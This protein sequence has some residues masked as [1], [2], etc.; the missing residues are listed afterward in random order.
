MYLR[1]LLVNLFLTLALFAENTDAKVAKSR[2]LPEQKSEE[3]QESCEHGKTRSHCNECGFLLNI[4]N[5]TNAIINTAS[6]TSGTIINDL[7]E[8]INTTNTINTTTMNTQST[9]NNINTNVNTLL[10]QSCQII[11]LTLSNTTPTIISAPGYY[12]VTNSVDMPITGAPLATPNTT[13]IINS[14]DVTL[15]LCGH[16]LTG[17]GNKTAATIISPAT[18]GIQNDTRQDAC[19]CISINPSGSASSV[20]DN[21]TITNGKIQYYSVN[22]IT[23][24][25]VDNLTIEDLLVE[26]CSTVTAAF[27]TVFTVTLRE[28]TSVIHNNVH[29]KSNRGSD[30]VI[31]NRVRQG[32]ADIKITNSSSIGLRGGVGTFTNSLLAIPAYITFGVTALSF[33]VRAQT[34]NTT[35]DNVLVENCSVTDAKTCAQVFGIFF[36][37]R[38]NGGVI[39]NCRITSVNQVTSDLTIFP[40]SVLTIEARGIAVEQ[41]SRG[42]LV[43]NCTVQDISMA[44]TIAPI[45]PSSASG[46]GFNEVTGGTARNCIVRNISTAGKVT[47]TVTSPASLVDCS[48]HAFGT[49]A[50]TNFAGTNLRELSWVNCIAS[51]IDGGSSSA[52]PSFGIG[53]KIEITT[54]S[55]S[56][57][58][59]AF[60][61]FY[62]NCLAQDTVGSNQSAGFT[63]TMTEPA[64]PVVYENCVT[65][66][67][68]IHGPNKL[69]NGFLISPGNNITMRGCTATGHTLNGFDLSGYL[70]AS[71]TGNAKFILD[72]C[73]ANGNSGYGFRLDHS[74]KQIELIDCK[75]TNNG[76][77]GINAAGR[78]MVFRNTVSDINLGKGF[79]FDQYY[80][81]FAKV[82]TDTSNVGM[83]N[84][85]V[86][87]VNGYTVAYTS[88]SQSLNIIPN[89]ASD[90]LPASLT[91]NGVTVNNGD[92]VLIKDLTGGN[93]N[94]GGQRNGVYQASNSTGSAVV[95]GITV[96][97]WQLIRVDPWRAP[98]TVP[99]GTKIL[100]AQSNAPNL[101]PGPVMYTLNTNVVVD[102][103]NITSANFIA[104]QAVAPDASIIEVAN[105]AAAQNSLNGFHNHAKDVTVR[106]CV[107]D[108]NGSVGFLDDVVGGALANANLYTRNRAFNND[109]GTTLGNYTIDYVIPANPTVLQTGTINPPVFPSAVAPEANVSITPS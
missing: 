45:A 61:A 41:S 60:S 54:G 21:I 91:I 11:P 58:L 84:L 26:N 43:E 73:I 101:T 46:I 2:A 108:R 107:A 103:T 23:A 12:K 38:V 85:G 30:F 6:G 48:A 65:E 67:D 40:A 49:S 80:P 28:C 7:N 29:Y 109:G 53:F 72:N 62:S 105:C 39:R 42:A 88:S 14:G 106:D 55:S 4:Y 77:D 64:T 25:Y 78:N 89:N 35:I 70:V 79:F 81:F 27:F 34:A 97:I 95:S 15:D 37:N 59:K 86:Y 57:N 13:I 24:Q 87:I 5:N 66:Q 92:I 104:T 47:V 10:G 76:L 16:V 36:Q 71:S 50:V 33:V 99:T 102:T 19:I 90:P 31:N 18:V 68:R 52:N 63:M 8:I 1:N 51:N 9:V 82:A 17:S 69:S 93:T 20:L 3:S 74:L 83:A 44:V 32:P 98:N 56:S 22:A 100:V 94:T 75:A 96:P